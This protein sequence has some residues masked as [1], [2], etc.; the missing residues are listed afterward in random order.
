MPNQ[1]A[2]KMAAYAEMFDY[3]CSKQGL[4]QMANEQEMPDD[5]LNVLEEL[6]NG[7]YATHEEVLDAAAE[8]LSERMC[9]Q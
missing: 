1:F 4:L 3:P 7:R 2:A 8:I 5:I 6:P 9:A